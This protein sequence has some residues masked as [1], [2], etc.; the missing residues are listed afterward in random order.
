M[1]FK[2]AENKLESNKDLIDN[3]NLFAVFI[4]PEANT[5][6]WINSCYQNPNVS[7]SN[8]LNALNDRYFDK[9]TKHTD[10]DVYVFNKQNVNW[11]SSGGLLI[12]ISLDQHL[13]GLC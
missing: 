3:S 11:I 5:A 12:P 10:V 13:N 8:F 6:E 1:T 7:L 4:A 9:Y 2:E